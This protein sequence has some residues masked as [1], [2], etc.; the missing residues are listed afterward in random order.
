M[1]SNPDEARSGDRENLPLESCITLQ[2]FSKDLAEITE[3]LHNL[4]ELQDLVTTCFNL[5]VDHNSSHTLSSRHFYLLF[6]I[7]RCNAAHLWDEIRAKVTQL[8]RT[9]EKNI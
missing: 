4:Q 6:D 8:Q 3:H 2:S 1:V 7:Y 9:V 5:L